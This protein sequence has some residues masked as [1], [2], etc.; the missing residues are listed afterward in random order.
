MF[1]IIFLVYLAFAIYYNDP[2]WTTAQVKSRPT[3]IFI[4]W[5]SSRGLATAR[6]PACR[7]HFGG[8]PNNSKPLGVVLMLWLDS[9]LD[10]TSLS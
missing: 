4:Y 9:H 6:L 5:E 1:L 8:L 10:T 7:G 2:S 3:L